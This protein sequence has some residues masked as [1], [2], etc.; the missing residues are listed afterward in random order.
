MPKW[1]KQHL[2]I[3]VLITFISLACMGIA[4]AA[5]LNSDVEHLKYDVQHTKDQLP[6]ITERLVRVEQKSDDIKDSLYRIERYI[7]Q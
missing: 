2:N 4:Y 3:S 1:L 6:E 7:A 5:V